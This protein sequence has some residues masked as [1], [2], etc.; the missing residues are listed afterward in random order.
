[1]LSDVSIKKYLKS[2]DI[3]VDPI[4]NDMIRAAAV[5]LHLGDS[6]LIPDKKTVIDVKKGKLPKYRQIK[7][8]DKSPFPLKSNMFVIGQTFEQI[9]ISERIGMIL[10]GR[11]TF[12]RLGISVTQTAILV[13]TGQ[14]PMQMALEIKNSGPNT[15]LLY[16]KMRFC[17]ACFFLLN[18]KASFSY[19]SIGKYASG[20]N[21]KP[22]FRTEVKSG[23]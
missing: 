22:I 16:P 17:R 15:F 8:K 7:L 19:D 21:F 10:D 13:D 9:G 18:P 11:S 3:V 20:N 14:A 6:I 5:T 23:Y 4:T 12:A 1:M 2:G